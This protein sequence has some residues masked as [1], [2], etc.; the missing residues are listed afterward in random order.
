M[1]K[2]IASAIFLNGGKAVSSLSDSSVYAD[3]DPDQLAQLYSDHGADVLLVFDQS[4]GDEEHDLSLTLMRRMARITEPSRG[5]EEDPLCRMQEGS[6]ERFKGI[7][8][9]DA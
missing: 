7:E 8:P 3:C 9:C 4:D 6:P 1:E 5:R 2:M